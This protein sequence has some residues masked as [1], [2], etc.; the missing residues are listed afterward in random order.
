MQS[1][2]SIY[3]KSAKHYYYYFSPL[4]GKVHLHNQ[5]DHFPPDGIGKYLLLLKELL[6]AHTDLAS[7]KFIVI[8]HE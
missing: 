7:V 2:Q 8:W 1:L 4:K 5:N 6:W 3:A